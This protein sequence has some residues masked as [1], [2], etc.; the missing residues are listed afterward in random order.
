[1]RMGVKTYAEMAL[2]KVKARMGGPPTVIRDIMG[3]TRDTV[4]LAGA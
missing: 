2:K 1:M 4:L 3:G